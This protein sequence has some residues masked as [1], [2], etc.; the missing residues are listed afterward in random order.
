MLNPKCASWLLHFKIRLPVWGPR[1]PRSP[2]GTLMGCESGA[3]QNLTWQL[4]LRH[5]EGRPSQAAPCQ[6]SGQLRGVN[7]RSPSTMGPR[8]TVTARLRG[9]LDSH[10][11]I[12]A[13]HVGLE[14]GRGVPSTTRESDHGQGRGQGGSGRSHGLGGRRGPRGGSV[15]NPPSLR[16]S[17]SLTTQTRRLG[18][19]ARAGPPVHAHS[20]ERG[21]RAPVSLQE[22]WDTVKH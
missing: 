10:S 3:R 7:S 15:R 18:A 22:A 6:P 9:R 1:V 19:G 4:K 20:Q 12:P 16:P 13:T 2:L 21:T 5:W 17:L 14:A 8:A 11:K